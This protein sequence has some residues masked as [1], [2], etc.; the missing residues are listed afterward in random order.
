MHYASNTVADERLTGQLQVRLT[1]TLAKDL[2][3]AARRAGLDRGSYVR[4]LIAKEMSAPQVD[5]WVVERKEAVSPTALLARASGIPHAKLE[6]V[7]PPDGWTLRV[8]FYGWSHGREFV[9]P[10]TDEYKNQYPWLRQPADYV[11]VMKQGVWQVEAVLS[12]Q[13]GPR[14]VCQAILTPY[15][16][17]HAE[18]VRLQRELPAIKQRIWALDG[19]EVFSEGQPVPVREPEAYVG[20]LQN[21]RKVR[22]GLEAW[23]HDW[24]ERARVAALGSTGAG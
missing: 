19:A 4:H 5:A 23:I 1:K 3:A 12:V 20:E 11:F 13:G 17:P 9:G 16:E 21:L 8:R 6:L 24:A 7:G 15:R 2:E 18:I 22:D 14:A 10:L